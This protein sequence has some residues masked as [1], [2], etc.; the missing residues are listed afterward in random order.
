MP[1]ED[2]TDQ[3]ALFLLPEEVEALTYAEDLKAWTNNFTQV[4]GDGWICPS[5][6]ALESEFTMRI[7]HGLDPY[8]RVSK[9]SI[10]SLDRCLETLWMEGRTDK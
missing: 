3:S 1:H 5:C 10:V 2:G 8:E 4:D 9:Y 6:G 7:N